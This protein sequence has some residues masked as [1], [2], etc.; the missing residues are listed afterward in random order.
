MTHELYEVTTTT[1]AYHGDDGSVQ[2]IRQRA[3]TVRTRPPQ[4]RY[5]ELL[6]LGDL[7]LF[8][9]WA[10]T[11][12]LPDEAEILANG[13]GRGAQLTSTWHERLDDPE[14]QD[15]PRLFRAR[16]VGESCSS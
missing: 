11:A 6:T 15:Q 9:K 8:V 4:D 12:G 1:T 7:R 16:Q 3:T 13:K 2:T 5:P 14:S 10:D